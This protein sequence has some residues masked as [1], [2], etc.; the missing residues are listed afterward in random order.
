MVARPRHRGWAPIR[1]A[2]GAIFSS[3]T[4]RV[5][6]VT[7]ARQ[8]AADICHDLRRGELLDTAFD[9]DS[10][11]LDPRDRRFTRE[12]VYGMLRRRA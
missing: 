9:R 12:L 10:A 8:V 11:R 4:T 1:I 3:M 7:D 6:G 5:A 2:G